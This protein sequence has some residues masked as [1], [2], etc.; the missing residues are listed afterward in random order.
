MYVRTI[1]LEQRDDEETQTPG[2]TE[3]SAGD[4][5]STRIVSKGLVC[6]GVK[7][8]WWAVGEDPSLVTVRSSVFGSLNGFARSDAETFAMTLARNLLRQ[9]YD[10]ARTEQPAPEPIAD[11][12]PLAKPG[13]FK[14]K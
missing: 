13:W 1:V 2:P 7:F 8:Q 4:A 12:N 11:A 9:H 14:K 5:V 3:D 6:D 10:S